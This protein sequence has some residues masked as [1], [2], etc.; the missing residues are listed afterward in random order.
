MRTLSTLDT[1]QRARLQ[2]WKTISLGMGIVAQLF[3]AGDWY[4]FAAVIPFISASLHLT[5]LQIGIVQGAFSITYALGMILWAALSTRMSTRAL[6]CT[7]L[8]GVGLFMLVQAQAQ[9]Y[10]ALVATRLAVGFFDAAVWI[11]AAKLIVTWFPPAQRGRAL[12][13]LLAAFSLA[14]TLDFALG[15]PLAAAIGWRGFFVTLAVGTL[16]VAALGGVLVKSERR[17]TGLPAFAWDDEPAANQ[18]TPR[19][20]T[21]FKSR[22]FYIASLAIFGDMFAISATATWVVPAFIQTQSMATESA[23]TVGT[24]MGLSQVVILLV[25]GYC[26]DLFRRRVLI[27]KVGALLSLASALAFLLTVQFGLPYAG[28][29]AVAAFSGVAVFSGGAI[30]ALLSEKYGD[31]LSGN[32]IGY[33]EMV[34]ISSTLVA[35]ALLGAVIQASG[36]FVS[37]FA[38][39]AGVQLVIFI[40][41]MCCR[42]EQHI[43]RHTARLTPVAGDRA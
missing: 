27:M 33:A 42:G 8:C 29:L 26:S 35:P 43:V 39:F 4:G 36:S 24:L 16:L 12:S 34:G 23:A 37:A 31:Q 15:I 18:A 7:G 2:R 22:W 9:S 20:S 19:V 40:M 28:L 1:P 32:A 10:E 25:G 14:I 13:A 6:Y 17:E 11:A 41:L 30:F 21:I 5:P 38:V 3:L